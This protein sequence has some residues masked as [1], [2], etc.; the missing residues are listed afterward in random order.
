[1]VSIVL[2]KI[3]KNLF[4]FAQEDANSNST[5]SQISASLENTDSLANMEFPLENEE[6]AVAHALKVTLVNTVKKQ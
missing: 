5:S 6:I 4:L 3:H 1:M 2:V